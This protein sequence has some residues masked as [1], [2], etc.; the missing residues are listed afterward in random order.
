MRRYGK[1]TE[2]RLYRLYV[3]R[4]RRDTLTEHDLGELGMKHVNAAVEHYESHLVA[5]G[6]TG[7]ELEQALKDRWLE[8]EGNELRFDRTEKC[9]M[10]M[11]EAQARV[12]VGMPREH[13]DVFLCNHHEDCLECSCYREAAEEQRL[14]FEHGRDVFTGD[15][16]PGFQED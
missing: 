6:L 15:A 1:E 2:F 13:R 3:C 10:L 5:V 14:N 12:K 16:I 8:F 7:D 9:L 4:R 11:A